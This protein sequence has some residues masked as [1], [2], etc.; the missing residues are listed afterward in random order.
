MLK[1]NVKKQN[2]I[3]AC[4]FVVFAVLRILLGVNAGAWFAA[5][6]VCDDALLASYSELLAHFM[7][8]SPKSL[9]KVIGYSVFLCAVE[10]SHVPYTVCLSVLWLVTGGLAYICLR[11]MRMPRAISF[12]FFVYVSFLPQ[13]FENWCGTRIY[14]NAIIGPFS[15]ISLFLMIL[16][17]LEI[18][19][20]SRVKTVLLAVFS[21]L[22]ISFTYYIK[23]DGLWLFA[24]WLFAAIMCVIKLVVIR[25][26]IDTKRLVA[27]AISIAIPFLCFFVITAGY[28]G[29]N[30]KAF[31]VYEVNTRASGESGKFLGNLY[32]ISSPNRTAELWAPVDVVEKAFEVSPTL[33]SSPELFEAMVTSPWSDGDAYVY[34]IYGDFW[35]WVLYTEGIKGGAW[36]NDAEKEAFFKQVNKE[37]AEAFKNGS[38]EKDK[39]RI[40]LLGSAGSRTVDEILE[41][42]YLIAAG[43]RGA[44]FYD[45]YDFG[46]T[47]PNKAG[48]TEEEL[49]L[50]NRMSNSL[51]LSYLDDMSGR[52]EGFEKTAR[53]SKAISEMYAVV[54]VALIAAVAVALAF[55][56]VLLISKNRKRLVVSNKNGLLC[57][58]MSIVFLGISV[59]YSFAIAWFSSFTNSNG[60]ISMKWMNYYNIALPM[61]LAI[62]YI[63]ATGCLFKYRLERKNE[64]NREN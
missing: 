54:N 62:S 57:M 50:S 7:F 41:L 37:L 15:G 32:K 9:L 40:S 5:N 29:L 23:E 53:I 4:L 22:L 25:K 44:I 61:L 6:E 27:G 35:G 30:Y 31:G 19:A 39:N 38:L 51:H 59:C 63:F 21:G 11:R 42:R 18:G 45:G 49:R 10:I 33:K 46:V 2:I 47:V 64:E 28:K 58:F 24:C 34:P 36:T 60:I 3:M 16:L 1:N 26:N 20:L 14:R 8:P 43:F 48:Y 52:L 55:S 12:F 56:F 13:A 17:F